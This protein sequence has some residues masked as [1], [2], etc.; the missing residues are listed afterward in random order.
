MDCSLPDLSDH[1]IFQARIL[2]WVAISYSRGSSNPEI[3][4]VSLTSLALASG[5]CKLCLIKHHSF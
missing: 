1:R 2:K 4:S 3:E 5:F